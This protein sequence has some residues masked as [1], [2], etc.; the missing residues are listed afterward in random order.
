MACNTMCG[1][2][3]P[4]GVALDGKEKSLTKKNSRKIGLLLLLQN[5]DLKMMLE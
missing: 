3:T 1:C 5:Y 2:P 4:V